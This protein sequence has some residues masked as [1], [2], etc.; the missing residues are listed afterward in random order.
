MK[1][2]FTFL[3]ALGLVAILFTACG[4]GA[5]LNTPTQPI[6]TPVPPSRTPPPT[7]PPK[8]EPTRIEFQAEDGRTLIGY[9]YPSVDPNA[10]VVVLMHMMGTT[11]KDWVKLGLV[12]WLQNWPAR[13]GGGALFAPAL[14]SAIYPLIP[15]GISFNVFTFDYRGFG[16]SLPLM[17]DKMTGN[18]FDQWITGWVLDSKAGYERAMTLPGVDQTRIV[19]IGASIGADGVVDA[20]ADGCLGALSLSPGDYLNVKYTTAVK[21]IDDSGKPVWCIAHEKDKPSAQTCKAASGTQ[22]KSIIYSEGGGD[23]GTHGMMFLF[24]EQAPLDIGQHIL[25]FLFISFNINP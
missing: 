16:E 11:Q 1:T 23:N 14:Q 8:P 25:D 19:G 12:D 22:Y 15:Q 2:R 24:S 3:V 5:V 13:S 17:P 7:I 10:P 20:C 18:E 21:K 6:N 9:F 4:S